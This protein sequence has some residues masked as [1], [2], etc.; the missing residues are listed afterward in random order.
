MSG[1]V[2]SLAELAGRTGQ[3]VRVA[4]IDSG[5]HADHPHVGPIVGGTAFDDDGSRSND[6]IDRLGH[7]TAVAAA[8]HEKAPEAPLVA[9][10][11]FDR[12][13]TTTGRALIEAIRWSADERVRLINLSLGT[14]NDEHRPALEQAVRYAAAAGAIVVSAAP[15]PGRAWL[16]GGLPGV[17]AVAVDW[18]CPRDQCVVLA[19]EGEGLRLRASGYP[20]PIPGV[21]PE[22]NLRGQSFAVANA[23][24]FLALVVES[25]PGGSARELSEMLLGSNSRRT[26]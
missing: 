8:I 5:V 15:E 3:G 9:V 10:R 25:V 2:L 24:G 22:R 21:P 7:G 13:L 14:L 1:R 6:L 16:P 17:V 4:V 11:V 12:A 18:S 19:E 20:R 23:T 26:L